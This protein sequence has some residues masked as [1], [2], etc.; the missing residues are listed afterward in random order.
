MRMHFTS[1]SIQIYIIYMVVN[2]SHQSDTFRQF[3]NDI[4]EVTQK[5]IDATKLNAALHTGMEKLNETVGEQQKQIETLMETNQHLI[6]EN[7]KL[8]GMTITQ[9]D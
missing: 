7:E 3:I 6:K 9:I 2:V 8:K 4:E 5:Y 1:Y